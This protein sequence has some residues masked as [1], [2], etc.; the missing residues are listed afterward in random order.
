MALLLIRLLSQPLLLKQDLG[1][2]HKA[3]GFHPCD[4]VRARRAR[5]D[6]LPVCTWE[7]PDEVLYFFQGK[8]V[9]VMSCVW[10]VVVKVPGEM[11]IFTR[12]YACKSFLRVALLSAAQVAKY[13]AG[14]AEKQGTYRD[15]N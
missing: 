2:V 7:S 1:S 8:P 12:I 13:N 10:Q 11:S 5:R 4:L 14:A 6:S 9:T 15:A 3:A